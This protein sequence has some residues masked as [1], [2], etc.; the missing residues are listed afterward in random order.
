MSRTIIVGCLELEQKGVIIL[1]L[2]LRLRNLVSRTNFL[3][4]DPPPS[5]PWK[6]LSFAFVFLVFRDVSILIVS[7]NH[8]CLWYNTACAWLAAKSATFGLLLAAIAIAIG[9]VIRASLA[10]LAFFSTSNLAVIL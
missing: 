3:H 8:T 10:W 1:H 6:I 5:R 2:L 7:L 9:V 4:F